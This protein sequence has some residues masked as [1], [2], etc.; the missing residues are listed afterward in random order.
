MGVGILDVAGVAALDGRGLFFD[1]GLEGAC[2]KSSGMSFQFSM[3]EGVGVVVEGTRTGAEADLG[4]GGGRFILGDSN[5]GP[6]E[7]CSG[8]LT[9][10]GFFSQLVSD[11]CI[12][13]AQRQACLL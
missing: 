9:E 11:D 8:C 2:R 5:G 10:S 13:M 4:G 3:A 7:G 1:R 12:V 6:F